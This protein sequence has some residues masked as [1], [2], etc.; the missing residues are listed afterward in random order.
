M[1]ASA[2]NTHIVYAAAHPSKDP[3][4]R[5]SDT[6]YAVDYSV[7]TVNAVFCSDRKQWLMENKDV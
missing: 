1:V 6:A 2:P 5:R 4:T 3:E 7:S